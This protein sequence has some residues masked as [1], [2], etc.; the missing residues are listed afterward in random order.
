MGD[1]YFQALRRFWSQTTPALGTPSYAYI[2]TDREPESN[3]GNADPANGVNHDSDLAY[4][5][6][7]MRKNGS[8]KTAKLSCAMLDYW[9]SFAVSLT[10][11]D[12]KGTERTSL[13]N[14]MFTLPLIPAFRT[15]LGGV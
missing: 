4:L 15:L 13:D 5:F 8:P 6:L 11:N 10:P 1:I 2:L 7:D 3:P 12:G 9:I 14:F